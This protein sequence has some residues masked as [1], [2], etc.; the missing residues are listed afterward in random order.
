MM[1]KQTILVFLPNWVGDVVMAT[2]LL[3]ALRKQRP[4][5]RIVHAGRAA[6]LAM[7]NAGVGK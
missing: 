6:P 2:P 1:N 4:T 7:L 3:A 5:D